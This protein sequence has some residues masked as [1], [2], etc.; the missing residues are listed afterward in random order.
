MGPTDCALPMLYAAQRKLEVDVFVVYTDSETWFG[1]VHPFQALAQY[2][3]KTGI[4]AKLVAVGMVP[5]GFTIADPSDA[6]MLDVVGFDTAAPGPSWP[7]SPA[8]DNPG[9]Q[10]GQPSCSPFAIRPHNRPIIAAPVGIGDNSSGAGRGQAQV[11]STRPIRAA[12]KNRTRPQLWQVTAT[13]ASP[14]PRVTPATPP[15]GRPRPGRT[16]RR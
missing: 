16:P 1:E 13:A 4:L 15:R 9:E 6:G 14:C 8:T 2:R 7:T 11:C 10:E 5:N 3:Q 12:E